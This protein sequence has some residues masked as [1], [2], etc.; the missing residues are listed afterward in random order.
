MAKRHNYKNLKIWQLGL[1]IANNISDVLM[2]FPKHERYDLC[3]QLSRCSI[4]I[5]SNI[6]EGSART[7]K[8]FKIF[9]DY[10]LGSS[11][12]LGTQLLV[13]NHRNYIDGETLK[14]L[15]NKIEEWQR[16]TM[17]FQNNLE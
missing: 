7:D 16:M 13:A 6:A 14:L 11:F 1:D 5:P 2:K 15:E 17:G 12:E 9:I 10:S 8:S 3:S 4:S